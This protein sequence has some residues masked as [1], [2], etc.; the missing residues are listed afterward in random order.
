MLISSIVFS[1]KGGMLNLNIKNDTIHYLNLEKLSISVQ[2]IENLAT[3]TM[4]MRFYNH[5][6]RILEGELNFPLGEGQNIS[7]F[8]MDI[9]GNMREGVVIEKA[10]GTEVFESIVYRRVDP[11]LLEMTEGNNFKS[12]VYPI[13]PKGFKTIIIAFEHELNVVKNQYLYLLPLNIKDVIKEFDVK[14]EVFESELKPK[15]IDHELVT[16]KFNKGNKGYQSKFSKSNFKANEQLGFSIPIQ[17]KKLN[18]LTYRGVTDSISYFYKTDNISHKT[19]KKEKPDGITIY[20]DNSGSA[21]QKNS[22]KELA[23]FDEYFKWAGNVNV[24][25]ITFA[26]EIEKSILFEIKNGNWTALRL[27]LEQLKPDGGTQLGILNFKTAKYNEIMF[28]CDGLSNYGKSQIQLSS[29]PV[30]VINSNM[31]ANH[32][33]LK[34]IAQ[35]TGGQYINLNN[36]P[37]NKALEVLTTENL[38][39]LRVEY[40]EDEISDLFINHPSGDIDRFSL[41]G[42]INAKSADV[43]LH[44]GYP[45]KKTLFTE[46]VS[47]ENKTVLANPLLERYWVQQKLNALNVNFQENK[48]EI[49]VIGKKYG[50]V[51]KTTS[52][53]VLDDIS[54]Y[55]NHHIVPPKELQEEYYAL[56]EEKIE[57]EKQSLEERKEDVNSLYEDKV[58]WWKTDWKKVEENRV[59]RDSLERIENAKLDSLRR[60]EKAKLDSIVAKNKFIL[61]SIEKAEQDLLFK[62]KKAFADSILMIEKI[63]YDSLLVIRNASP[64]KEISGIVLSADAKLPLSGVSIL[65]LGT[66]IGTIT[67]LEGHFSIKVPDK[68]LVL[69]SY[70]GFVPQEIDV[71]NLFNLSVFL[72]KD[73]VI[74]DEVIIMASS[75]LR[76]SLNISGAISVVTAE[77]I[78]DVSY[79]AVTGNP[80]DQPQPTIE[81]K[82][83]NPQVPYLDSLKKVNLSDAYAKHLTIRNQYIES[84][85]YFLDV[86]D[87]FMSH[88]DTTN[89]VRVLS[90]LSEMRMQNHEILRV[91]GRKL[92][93]FGE[94]VAAIDVFKKVLELRPFEPHS[95]RDLGLAYAENKE[96]QKAIE[97]LYQII[98]TP[99]SEH[100]ADK[101]EGIE[102]IV[103]GE[104]NSI[105]VEARNNLDVGFIDNR[106]LINLPADIRVVLNWDA[107]NTD[108]D[109][110]VTDPLNEK[111]FY[112]HRYTKI[113]GSVSDDLMDGYGPEEF[114]LKKAIDGDY[115]IEVEYFGSSQQT[116]SGPVTIQ[117]V[118]F[119]NFGKPNETMER[120]TV[121]LSEN[122]KA[123]HIGNLLFGLDK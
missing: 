112:S 25:F 17:D 19:K 87:F 109:L 31:V 40:K 61:D 91:L 45:D 105:I 13:N 48:D 14:V 100:I 10:K 83:W 47:I 89:A 27:Y 20:W 5:T 76:R 107:D 123:I 4:T 82:E 108:M 92:L 35:S 113:G 120:M 93:E 69:F 8:A 88:N 38:Q 55:V 80:F 56:L 28:F 72:K 36:T 42:K 96:F 18:L 57:E 1:Q 67:D 54:D 99:W 58:S 7:R 86:A 106:F 24:E 50:F 30:S 77:S 65:A 102:A 97:T 94:T 90:N 79:Q 11:G 119:T 66:T 60:V 34:Y 32:S 64:L 71:S 85:S 49:T 62:V 117:V 122:D 116:I 63:K 52:L 81:L 95:Y 84:P 29:K 46:K 37:L 2:V 43:V 74:L 26:N 16:L 23:L 59:R 68:A 115:K 51:T 44:F 78:S 111:C 6:N 101:F 118:V 22:L 15:S 103:I 104:I 98:T 121:R 41:I 73:D 33:Y 70:I 12:R 21:F 9:D 53:I 110:W 75:V 39:L 3:T 114:L